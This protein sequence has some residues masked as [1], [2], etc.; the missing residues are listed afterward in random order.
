MAEKLE[1]E[2]TCFN[3]VRRQL[4]LLSFLIEGSRQ[5]ISS[6]SSARVSLRKRDQYPYPQDKPTVFSSIKSD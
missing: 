1:A 5:D 4:K 2:I 3:R 6:T